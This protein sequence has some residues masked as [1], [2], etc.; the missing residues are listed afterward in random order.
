ML[1]QTIDF[2]VASPEGTR[3]VHVVR[4]DGVAGFLDTLPSGQ[5]GYLRDTGFAGTAGALHFLPGPDGI[6]GAVLGIGAETS[7]FAFG[8]LSTQLPGIGAWRL[9]PGDYDEHAA[10]LGYCLGAYR[11]NRFLTAGRKPASLFVPPDHKSSLMQAAATWMVRDLINTPPNIL[12]PVELADFS[13]SMADRY[14]AVSVVSSGAA[15]EAAYPTVAAVGRGSVR[16]PR[17]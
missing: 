3:P 14:G 16:P 5:A 1:D 10:T 4:P 12:G 11:Y 6:A 8:N 13:V 2:I 9:L 15:L 7:P 17:V